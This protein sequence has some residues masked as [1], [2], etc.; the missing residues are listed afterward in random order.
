MV[1]G[2]FDDEG[3]RQCE[4]Q[5]AM[6]CQIYGILESAAKDMWLAVARIGRLRRSAR[7]PLVAR[8]SLSSHRVAQG[9]GRT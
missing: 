1:A 6:L 9:S 4:R 5:H 7:R 3:I 8:R 2:A